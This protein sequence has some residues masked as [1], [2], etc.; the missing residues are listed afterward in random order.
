M[1]AYSLTTLANDPRHDAIIENESGG[2]GE[3]IQT[4]VSYTL[5]KTKAEAWRVASPTHDYHEL[6]ITS[7][8]DEGDLPEDEQQHYIVA[9]ST[10]RA[11]LLAQAM[12]V[13]NDLLDWNEGDSGLD[14]IGPII[15]KARTLKHNV[16]SKRN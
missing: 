1:K 8:M 15:A 14:G 9:I 2:L 10:I 13:V 11:E 6:P 5:D 12:I 4:H 3:L 16:T 7:L